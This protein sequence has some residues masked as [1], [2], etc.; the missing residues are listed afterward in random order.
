MKEPAEV[1]ALK[2]QIQIIEDELD[3]YRKWIKYAGLPKLQKARR[4]LRELR[5]YL[6]PAVL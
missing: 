3:T 6:K 4:E 5:A 2:E 1:A